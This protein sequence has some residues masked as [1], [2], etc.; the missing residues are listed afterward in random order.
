M[1]SRLIKKCSYF[2]EN[3]RYVA[4][5]HRIFNELNERTNTFTYKIN[6][7]DYL[8]HYSTHKEN[9]YEFVTIITNRRKLVLKLDGEPDAGKEMYVTIHRALLIMSGDDAEIERA[10]S[11]KTLCNLD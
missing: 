2:V 11:V 9:M 4:E 7:T 5:L 10:V 3:D 8:A 1:C 6:E